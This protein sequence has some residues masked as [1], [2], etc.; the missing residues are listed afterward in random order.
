MSNSLQL[1]N[2]VLGVC[3]KFNYNDYEL[4]IGTRKHMSSDGYRLI[5]EASKGSDF[6]LGP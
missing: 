4:A 1:L 3:G 2:G 5:E 6:L